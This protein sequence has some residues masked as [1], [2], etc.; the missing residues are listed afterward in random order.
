M[1]LASVLWKCDK[2]SNYSVLQRYHKDKIFEFSKII[3]ILSTNNK[4]RST[5]HRLR[6]PGVGGVGKSKSPRLGT[7]GPVST[8]HH[9]S[10]RV[11]T[12]HP[13]RWLCGVW[14]THSVLS[15]PRFLLCGIRCRAAPSCPPR[16]VLWADTLKAFD[17]HRTNVQIPGNITGKIGLVFRGGRWGRWWSV[18]YK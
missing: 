2:E 9:T 15:E 18:S 13:G 6:Q 17:K 4:S 10:R 8:P 3:N 14:T 16:G 7:N 11:P 5:E 1:L 12:R